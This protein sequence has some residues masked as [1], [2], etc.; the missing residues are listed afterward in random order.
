MLRIYALARFVAG[1]RKELGLT[2][3]QLATDSRL[4]KATISDLENARI[5][6]PQED[7]MRRLA[8]GL[9]MSW[10][11]LD[12]MFTIRSGDA[13]PIIIDMA[14]QVP[15]SR[16]WLL[17]GVLDLFTRPEPEPPQAGA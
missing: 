11:D 10:Q 2:T 16:H 15:V 17:M 4:S 7:T 3:A 8:V 9:Q 12:M 1:R 14:N 13:L 6:E 5:R